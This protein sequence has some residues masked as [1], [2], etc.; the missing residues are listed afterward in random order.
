M[1]LNKKGQ[2]LSLNVIIV[3][4]IALIVL[5][6]LVAVFIGRINIFGQGLEQ[7]G[8]AQLT[9]MQARYGQCAPTVNAEST[10]RSNYNSAEADDKSR[11]TSE[12]Q[13]EINRCKRESDNRA[14]CESIDCRWRG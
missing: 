9:A 2:G 1:I 6:V 10:F 11:Y 13:D 5:V 7:S 8:D 3:A 12:Y 4:A 14:V